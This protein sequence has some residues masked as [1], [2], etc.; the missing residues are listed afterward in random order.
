MS[1][2]QGVRSVEVGLRLMRHLAERPGP[3]ALKDLAAAAGMP[4]AKAHRYLVS[5][6]RAGMAEQ[7]S[8]SGRYRLGPLALDLGLAALRGVDV[9][10]YGAEAVADLVAAID[11]TVLLAIWGNKG[12]VVARWGESSRP[13][14]TN[15]R[16][17]WVMPMVNSATGRCFA[18]YLPETK[19][20]PLLEAEFSL[21]PNERAKYAARLAEIRA[22][23]LCRVE[24]DLLRGVAAVAAPV[25]DHTGG[26]VAVLAALGLQGAFDTSWDGAYAKAVGAAADKLSARLGYKPAPE[27]P[28]R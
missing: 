7:E 14:A 5:L 10:K 12:P 2:R 11:E 3:V 27:P 18:A 22:H 4:A 24:G 8:E 28:T 15:V 21:V 25:F 9:L 23:R 16:A 20:L 13:V 6:I 26:I 17:G 19:T 1:E